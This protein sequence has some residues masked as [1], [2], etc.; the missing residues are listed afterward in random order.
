M[1]HDVLFI[2]LCIFNCIQ[3]PSYRRPTNLR[4]GPRPVECPSKAALDW[5]HFLLFKKVSSFILSVSAV[6]YLWIK[7]HKS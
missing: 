3:Y 1:R 5:A 2:D 7:T 6:S 4:P